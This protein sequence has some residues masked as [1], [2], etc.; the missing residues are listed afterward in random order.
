[1][2]RLRQNQSGSASIII[3]IWSLSACPSPSQFQPKTHFICFEWNR[4]QKVP[5]LC[6]HISRLITPLLWTEPSPGRAGS[7]SVKPLSWIIFW[8]PGFSGTQDFHV[9]DILKIPQ[10]SHRRRG[11]FCVASRGSRNIAYGVAFQFPT[12]DYPLLCSTIWSPLLWIKSSS[13]MAQCNAITLD[14]M[15]FSRNRLLNFCYILSCHSA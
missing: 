14:M 10:I 8:T 4:N 7:G 15:C 3:G 13:S 12:E 1:M 5:L 6:F 11:D 2:K 9:A